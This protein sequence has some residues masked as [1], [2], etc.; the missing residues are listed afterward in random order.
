MEDPAHAHVLPVP[1][2]ATL[3]GFADAATLTPGV[4][5][6]RLEP[7]A[8]LS[9]DTRNSHYEIFVV[10]PADRKLIVQGGKF[11]VEP[12]EVQLSGSSFGGTLLKLGWIGVGMRMEM[13]AGGRRIITSPVKSIKIR[14]DAVSPEGPESPAEEPECAGVR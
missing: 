14:D 6:C 5:V 12:T 13:N 3:D 8:S 10:S 4:D 7:F 1:P 11:F 2:G 9:V